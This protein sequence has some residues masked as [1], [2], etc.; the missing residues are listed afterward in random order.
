MFVLMVHLIGVSIG[1]QPLIKSLIQLIFPL[2]VHVH[3][4]LSQIP[5]SLYT[6]EL[7]VEGCLRSYGASDIRH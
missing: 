2:L 7:I 5:V 6:I 3:V 4:K 1:L